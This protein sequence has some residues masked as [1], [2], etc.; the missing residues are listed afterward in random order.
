MNCPSSWR[1]RASSVIR[2]SVS[3]A[4]A[5]ARPAAA[6]GPVAVRDDD[7]GHEMRMSEQIGHQPMYVRGL[8]GVVVVEH[9]HDSFIELSYCWRVR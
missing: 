7:M 8:D 6:S 4:L 3:C 9:D 1:E 2:I 5:R